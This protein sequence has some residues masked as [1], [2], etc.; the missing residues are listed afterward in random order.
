[1]GSAGGNCTVSE[2]YENVL[3]EQEFM[4]GRTGGPA[5]DFLC[6]AVVLKSGE[7]FADGNNHLFTTFS[8]K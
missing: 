7:P 1:M 4:I 5:N 6:D 2:H 8:Q 3:Q